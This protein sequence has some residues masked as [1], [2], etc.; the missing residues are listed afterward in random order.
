M[1]QKN[2]NS[3]KHRHKQIE[4]MVSSMNEQLLALKESLMFLHVSELK[5]VAIRLSLS[6]KGNKMSLILRILHFMK[7]GEKLETPKFPEKSCAKRG[8]S[9]VLDEKEL[10]L[11]GTYKNDLKTR[12]FFKQLIGNHFHF[13]AFGI[14]WLNEKWLEGNP[15][16]Y[17][18]FATMWQEEYQKRKDIPVAPKEE[19]AYI[20]FVQK[21][22]LNN[23]TANRE[24]IS[25]EWEYERQG[26]KAN[27][28]KWIDHS[29]SN[30]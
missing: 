14:D 26:H 20:N 17:R 27:V 25:I 9:N 29:Y 24:A 12:L 16:T 22:T 23:P 4:S 13:T 7:T 1:L 3:Q 15:P 8:S 19:W 6:N 5:D 18:E 10:M 28:N 30:S 21:Y 2:K 11:K